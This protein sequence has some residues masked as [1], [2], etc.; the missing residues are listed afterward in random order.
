MPLADVRCRDPHGRWHMQ[1]QILH[2]VLA[3]LSM[4]A[5]VQQVSE[6]LDNWQQGNML[7]ETVHGGLPLS[8]NRL[9]AYEQS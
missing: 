7:V 3:D 5:Q 1:N 6:I 9:E 4:Q 8:H 2:P